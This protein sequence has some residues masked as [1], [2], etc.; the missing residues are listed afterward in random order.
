M[1]G[2]LLGSESAVTRDRIQAAKPIGGQSRT[3][4]AV[5]QGLPS[6]TPIAPDLDLVPRSARQRWL[7]WI[8]PVLVAL[9]VLGAALWYFVPGRRLLGNALGRF[10]DIGWGMDS[11]S[12]E[13]LAVCREFAQRKNDNDALAAELLGPVPVIP[14]EPVSQEE[15]DRL[16]AD[17]MLHAEFRVKD[18]R[19]E[20]SSPS[21]PPSHPRRYVLVVEGRFDTQPLWVRTPQG[22]NRQ[23]RSLY[24]PDIVVEVVDGRLHGVSARLHYDGP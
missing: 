15:A 11:R 14:V 19:R 3:T 5:R 21:V 20:K 2:E 23:Q 1:A 8:A 4:Q 24:N 9:A 7:V 12:V 6:S 16:D 17:F 13:D 22:S 18:V 10:A